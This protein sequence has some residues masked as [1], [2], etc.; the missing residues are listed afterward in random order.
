LTGCRD[1]WKKRLEGLIMNESPVMREVRDEARLETLREATLKATLKAIQ[2]R[3]PGSSPAL[4][5]R[6]RQQTDLSVL[7][8]WFDLSL[9]ARDIEAFQQDL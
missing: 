7:T 5:D 2:T 9:S 6:I 4:L 1:L 8:R 3:F